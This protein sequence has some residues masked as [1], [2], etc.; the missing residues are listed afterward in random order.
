M[1]KGWTRARVCAAI[2]LMAMLALGG[3]RLVAWAGRG[4]SDE[5][6]IGRQS[7]GTI[8]VPTGQTLQPAGGHYT[9]DGR[10][11]DMAL[12]PDGRIV[13]LLLPDSILLFDL[14]KNEFLPQSVPG[15]HGFGG[16]AWSPDGRTLYAGGRTAGRRGR[17]RETASILVTTFNAN[18]EPENEEPIVLPFNSRIRPN[19]NAR[20]ASVGGLALSPDGKTLYAA[21]FNNCTLAVIDLSSY[22]PASG[23]AKICEVPTGSSPE[24]VVVSPRGDRIYVSNRGGK[25]PETGD[26]ED[27]TDPVVVDP[28]SYRAAT[29]TVSIVD[30]AR[31]V[32][33]PE[34]AVLSTVRVG[35]QPAALALSQDARRLFVA[36]ANNDSVSV[37]ATGSAKVVETIPTSPAPGR[38]A[39]SSPNGLAVSPNGRKLFVTLAG[40]NCVEELD[41]DAAAGGVA[42]QT[43]IAGLIPT[44]WFPLGVALD[45]QARRLL[46][47]NNKGIG[48]LGGDRARPRHKG[49][50]T[51]EAG[52]GGVVTKEESVGRSVF[53]VLGS[54][55]VIAV[56]DAP[57]LA[58]YTALT[59]RNNHFDRM[60][61][62]LKRAP[63]PFWARFKHVVLIIKEN[64]TYDQILGD[65]S[66]PPGHIGGD[67]GLVMFG[68][69]I[70]PNHH[71]IAREFGLLDNLYCSGSVSADGHQW[72]NEAFASDYMERAMDRYPRSYPCCGTDP[73]S[74]AGNKFVWEAA[75]AA[76]RTFR[77]YGEFS[78]LQSMKPHEELDYNNVG[79]FS[80]SRGMDVAHAERV[81]RDLTAG[82]AGDASK[83][84]A[85]LTYIWLPNNHTFGTDPGFPTPESCVADNDLG[86]GRIVECLSHSKRY[87]RDEPTVVFVIED[88]AQGGVDHV[89]GHRTVGFA[90]SPFNRR[91]QVN[92]TNY[93]QLSMVRTIE[94][95]L[96]LKPL[97][98][99][100]AAAVPMRDCFQETADYTPY[101]AQ[102]NRVSLSKRNPSVRK[103]SGIER[104]WAAVCS[105]LDFSAPDRADPNKLTE[106]LWH[107]TH[108]AAAFPPPDAAGQ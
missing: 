61:L 67:A 85:Q 17:G 81:I 47:I 24:R 34:H 16:L 37:V 87:W 83:A 30:A 44:G 12:R 100:D 8:L 2:A 94:V 50:N 92:S 65:I 107:H 69:N 79:D 56:P 99:F 82:D 72:L 20:E 95:I 23:S 32:S 97:N 38:L 13:A 98:Q 1:A 29:G 58:H 42:P 51:P 91:H 6:V 106:A 93:N 64:R 104:R 68:E 74:Y 35:L 33:D 73:L 70:T 18:G 39:E 45:P 41:L 22:D 19:G 14:R 77:D 3:W 28:A 5:A 80:S 15:Q 31:A 66:V 84:L 78:P 63:D 7:N 55:S 25:V 36:N 21:L 59:A 89:E 27:R 43:K 71:A 49:P 62:A 108:G 88:D 4:E 48:S 103:A 102:K 53:A 101:V 76:G 52:P 11:I 86:L 96:G 54:L 105:R 40:D 75:M 10:P 90:I 60:T 57:T 46:V 26:T 9:F